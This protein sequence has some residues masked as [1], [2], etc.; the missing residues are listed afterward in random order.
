MLSAGIA[1]AEFDFRAMLR[2]REAYLVT[3]LHMLVIPILVGVSL[4]WLPDPQIRRVAVLTY[5]MPCGL[6]AVVFP[7]LV[8]ENCEI[9]ASAALLSNLIACLSIPVILTL[10]GI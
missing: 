10:F 2:R 7:K 1:V 9:G 3:V 8:D 4:F 6:N 5:A